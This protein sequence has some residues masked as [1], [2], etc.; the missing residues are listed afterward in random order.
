MEIVKEINYDWIWK[1][2]LILFIIGLGV[3]IVAIV[4]DHEWCATIGVPILA[5]GIVSFAIGIVQLKNSHTFRVKIND[6]YTVRELSEQCDYIEYEHDYG[7]WL[8]RFK[9]GKNDGK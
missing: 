9:N 4:T 5:F 2:G 7:T 3:L 1:V 6:A 8:V